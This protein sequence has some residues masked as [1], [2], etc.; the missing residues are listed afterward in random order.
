[1]KTYNNVE[2]LGNV[3]RDP[4]CRTTG[5][6]SMAAITVATNIR[7]KDKETGEWKERGEFTRAV[8]FGKVAEIIEEYVSKGS[9][10]F[11]TGA[12]RTRKFEK[13]G[14]DHYATEVIID[15]FIMCGSAQ[16]N[17][18]RR[19]AGINDKPADDFKDDDIPF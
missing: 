10:V 13:D 8:A 14:Q 5:N 4:Q 9:P 17:K 3:T 2:I 12:L 7:W 6:S 11:L 16:E 19:Q 1:M 18:A 15:E